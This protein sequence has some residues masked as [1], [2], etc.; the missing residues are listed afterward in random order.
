MIG[1]WN[2]RVVRDWL[3][4]LIHGDQPHVAKFDR[5]TREFYTQCGLCGYERRRI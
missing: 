2:W 3:H 5:V 1:R 4:D